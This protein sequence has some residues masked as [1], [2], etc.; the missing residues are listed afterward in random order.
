MRAVKLGG[1]LVVLGLLHASCGA[2][3]TSPDE[4]GEGGSSHDVASEAEKASANSVGGDA[5]SGDSSSAGMATGGGTTEVP[6]GSGGDDSG[7]EPDPVVAPSRWYVFV[8]Q[9]GVFAYDTTK[10][11]APDGLITLSEGYQFP[12][13]ESVTWSPNGRSVL[14]QDSGYYFVTELTD[15]PSTPRVQFE[16]PA[17]NALGKPFAWSADSNSLLMISG[18]TLST[19]DPSKANPSLHPI[20]STLHYYG[21]APRGDRLLYVDDAGAHV[22]QVDHGSP[23]SPVDI[24]TEHNVWA[25]NGK[26]LAGTTKDDE[27]ALTSL[28]GDTATLRVLTAL[29]HPAG[30]GSGGNSPPEPQLHSYQWVVGFNRD[31]S[32]L[33]FNAMTRDTETSY[34]I[35]LDP[36]PSKLRAVISG[37]PNDAHVRCENWSPDGTLLNCSWSKNGEG[38]TFAV[39]EGGTDP[40]TFFEAD[41]EHL[42]IWVWSADPSKHQLFTRYAPGGGLLMIDLAKP[43]EPVPLCDLSPDFWVSPTGELLSYVIGVNA[44]VVNLATPEAEALKI[45]P[46]ESGAG[47]ASPTWSPDGKFLS[48]TDGDDGQQRLIRVDGANLSTPLTLQGPSAFE[49]VGAWQP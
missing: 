18:L 15:F 4:P 29:N 20:T 7:Q 39:D 47:I 48:L 14:Y 9:H 23:S 42:N 16:N 31:G 30:Q 8:H 13:H 3:P 24:E 5:G 17:Y 45:P 22:V 1:V 35:S 25:P 34:L 28:S 33:A 12:W 40:T 32:N 43:N 36:Q 38:S 11:P 49:I 27:V 19:L 6:A 10:F 44:Y 46:R 2:P 26:Q 41:D 21:W 37:G